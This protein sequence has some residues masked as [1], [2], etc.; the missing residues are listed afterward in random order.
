MTRPKNPRTPEVD[1]P[2]PQWG[3]EANP[4]WRD[5]AVAWLEE[6]WGDS[7]AC[8]YCK[9]TLWTID[10]DIVQLQQFTAGGSAYGPRSPGVYPAIQVRCRTCGHIVLVGA[11]S[12]GIIP[13][14]DV[15][16]RAMTDTGPPDTSSAS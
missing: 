2:T 5:R 9:G 11:V 4:E 3:D 14:T 7:S 6:H 15:P 1:P 16:S 8:P 13:S 12:T 10:E